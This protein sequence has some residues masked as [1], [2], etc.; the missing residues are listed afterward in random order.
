M[1]TVLPQEQ[2]EP[3][4][5]HSKKLTMT[6]QMMAPGLPLLSDGPHADLGPRPAHLFNPHLF[7]PHLVIALARPLTHHRRHWSVHLSRLVLRLLHGHHHGPRPHLLISRRRPPVGGGMPIY[8]RHRDH[9][10]GAIGKPG[11]QVPGAGELTPTVA[12]G[13][14]C[15]RTRTWPSGRWTHHAHL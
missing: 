12:A 11:G 8:R 14:T 10:L 2:R 1:T 3:L 4:W 13:L 6:C 9:R 7:H 15:A 5:P